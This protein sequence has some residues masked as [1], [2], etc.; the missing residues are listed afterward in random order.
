MKLSKL[1]GAAVLGVL[2]MMSVDAVAQPSIPRNGQRTNRQYRSTR[3]GGTRVYGTQ[4]DWL[5]ER[6][7]TYNDIRYKDRGQV[8]V[9]LNAIYARHG[10]RFKDANLRAY[11][12]SQWWYTPRYNEIPSS[13]FNS[14]ENYNISFLSKYD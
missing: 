13:W 10:R 6:R 5:S 14:Y 4:Y 9:M 1:F 3:S 12:N 2:L 11:F 7:A 8:R